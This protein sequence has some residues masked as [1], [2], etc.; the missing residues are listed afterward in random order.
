MPFRRFPVLL[1]FC[2]VVAFTTALQAQ[3]APAYEVVISTRDGRVMNGRSI[4]Q[5]STGYQF[6]LKSARRDTRIHPQDIA[7]IDTVGLWAPILCRYLNQAGPN[8]GYGLK[9]GEFYYRTY[10]LTANF[11][12]FGITDYFS[13]GAGFDIA[14]SIDQPGHPLTYTVAPKFTIPIREGLVNLGIGG[15]F[16]NLPNYEGGF[17]THNFYHATLSLGTPSRHLSAGLVMLQIEGNLRPSPVYALNTRW[18]VNSFFALQAEVLTGTPL[19]GTVFLPGIQLIGH[20]FDFNLFYPLGKYDQ[21]VFTSP[22]PL[23]S[24]SFKVSRH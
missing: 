12:A 15:V 16:L 5:D 22:F 11:A 14:S 10:M 6:W 8:T 13:I 9:K 2:A 3:F 17:S 7:S 21:D 1:T 19:E 18:A 23:A 20:R 4:S 24:L